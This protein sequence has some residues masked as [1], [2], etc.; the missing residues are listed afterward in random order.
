MTSTES[1]SDSA[2]RVVKKYMIAAAGAGFVP[3]PLLDIALLAG[4]Q[5][6]MLKSLARI[7]G[8]QFVEQLGKS[9]VAALSGG[10]VSVSLASL[11]KSVPVIG[12]TLGMMAVPIMGGA[13]TYAIGKVFIQHFESGGTFLTF[14]PGQVEDYYSRNYEKG[15]EEVRK[16]FIGVKP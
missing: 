6:G 3:A 11:V 13:S 9:S 10:S 14:D 7:Y 4:I 5:L 16:S 1:K 12:H 2:D 8:I 15:R